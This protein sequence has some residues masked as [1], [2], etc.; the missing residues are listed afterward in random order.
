MTNITINT[1]DQAAMKSNERPQVVQLGVAANILTPVYK[2]ASD[3]K[4]YKSDADP[5]DT[6]LN[7]VAGLVVN[8]T[9]LDDYGYIVSNK[10]TIIDVGQSL[11]KGETWWLTGLGT[12]GQYSD[13]QTGDAEVILGTTN[14]N[15]KF[16]VN[17]I[18]LGTFKS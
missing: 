1:G 8:E 2:K 18:E 3:G 9:A 5:A 4:Y 6:T 13:V 16:V 7:T 12:V 17:I 11:T 14:D 10:G 15:Q